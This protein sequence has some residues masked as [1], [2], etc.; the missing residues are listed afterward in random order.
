MCYPQVRFAIVW[1]GLWHVRTMTTV[2]DLKAYA[3]VRASIQV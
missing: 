3:R 2:G 1:H